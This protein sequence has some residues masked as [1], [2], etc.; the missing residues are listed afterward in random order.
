MSDP[1]PTPDPVAAQP[2]SRR[3]SIRMAA[4]AALAAG[5]GGVPRDA[6]AEATRGALFQIKQRQIKLSFYKDTT[7]GGGLLGTVTLS[8][9]ISS[10]LTSSAGSRTL[11][12]WSDETALLGTTTLSPEVST[13]LRKLSTRA[14]GE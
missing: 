9:E 4:I 2:I 13:N 6:H 12:K 8:P 5:L 3:E 7:D 14:P 11:I 1:T 10:F